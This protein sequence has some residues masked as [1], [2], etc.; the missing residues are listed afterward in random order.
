MSLRIQFATQ[1]E[2]FTNLDYIEGLVILSIVQQE[3]IAAITV[4][5]EG[6][7]RTRL[8]GVNLARVQYDGFQKEQT[9]LEVHKVEPHC[10]ILWNRKYSSKP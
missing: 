8:S 4:K 10:G 9:Q 6:E 5:L 1:H 3:T 2:C 7:S